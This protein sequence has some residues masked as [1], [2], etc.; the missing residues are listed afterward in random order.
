LGLAVA[1]PRTK[2]G[3]ANGWVP[4]N[5]P[6]ENVV[7]LCE[8]AGAEPLLDRAEDSYSAAIPLKRV[9]VISGL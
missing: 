2:S 9:I 1:R 6:A 8:A 4:K 5:E 7:V 3:Q